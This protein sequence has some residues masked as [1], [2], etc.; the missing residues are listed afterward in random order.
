MG[1][2]SDQKVLLRKGREDCQLKF[3]CQ[4]EHRHVAV[5]K[6]QGVREDVTLV[7]FAFL[8]LSFFLCVVELHIFLNKNIAILDFGV[9]HDS[10]IYKFQKFCDQCKIETEARDSRNYT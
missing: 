1:P 9:S 4:G 10:E 2:Q 7:V 3:G 5:R 6:R 8:F